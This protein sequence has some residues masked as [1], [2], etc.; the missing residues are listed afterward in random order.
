MKWGGDLRMDA[1]DG[2][3]RFRVLLL[4][5]ETNGAFRASMDN[6]LLG[7]AEFTERGGDWVQQLGVVVVEWAA[8]RMLCGT[9]FLSCLFGGT[10]HVPG[11][12]IDGGV[13]TVRVTGV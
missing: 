10:W 11:T 7:H 8:A 6:H 5:Y 2:V 13:T 12:M 1:R 3:R 9:L 4:E